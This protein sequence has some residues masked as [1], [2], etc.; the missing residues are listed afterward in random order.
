MKKGFTLIELLAVIVVLAIIALITT[1][2]IINIISQAQEGANLRSVEGYAKALETAYYTSKINGEATD[3]NTL[4]AEYNGATVE[5]ITKTNCTTYGCLNNADIAMTGLGY[6]TSTPV[7][8]NT[9][10]SW[11]VNSFGYFNVNVV[12]DSDF[13][14][15]R[16]VITI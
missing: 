13:S 16:P 14:G 6:W 11:F 15:V 12:N 5:C 7:F 8:G 1:P 9:S 4:T 2:I 10:Y 3:L